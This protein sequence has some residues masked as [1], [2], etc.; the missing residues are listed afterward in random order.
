MRFGVTMRRCCSTRLSR[1]RYFSST[2]NLLV[3]LLIVP[4]HGICML[5]CVRDARYF[6]LLVMWAKTRMLAYFCSLRFWKGASYSPLLLDLPDRRGRR[7][8]QATVRLA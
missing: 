1:W 8:A 7:K 4:V 3:L 5:L 2:K 6:D